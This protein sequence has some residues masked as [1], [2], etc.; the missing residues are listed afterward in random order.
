MERREGVHLFYRDEIFSENQSFL[1]G[2]QSRD[3]FPSICGNFLFSSSFLFFSLEK[4]LSLKTEWIKLN[5]LMRR[6]SRNN[7]VL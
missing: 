2:I 7:H 3:L 6:F 5:N 1:R 4:K